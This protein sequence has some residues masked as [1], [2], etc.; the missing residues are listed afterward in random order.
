M[1]RSEVTSSNVEE[2][3]Y[4]AE[5]R[6]LEVMFRGGAVYQYHGVPE[7]VYLGLLDAPSVG[8]YLGRSIKGVYRCERLE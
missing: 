6:T 8:G 2:V 4:D 1:E 7:D 5:A 3:G